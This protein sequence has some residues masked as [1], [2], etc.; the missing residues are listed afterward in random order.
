MKDFIEYERVIKTIIQTYLNL[1]SPTL[2]LLLEVIKYRYPPMINFERKPDM[3]LEVLGTRFNR[4]FDTDKNGFVYNI[5]LADSF[6]TGLSRL[7]VVLRLSKKFRDRGALLTLGTLSDLPYYYNQT[8]EY[9]TGISDT[10]F[11]SLT[12]PF[13]GFPPDQIRILKFPSQEFLEGSRELVDTLF[14]LTG[15][16]LTTIH[17]FDPYLVELYLPVLLTSIRLRKKEHINDIINRILS[18]IFRYRFPRQ[19]Y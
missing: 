4:Y 14:G 7:G 5:K 6:Y 12:D 19:T 17:G 8:M 9:V 3:Y 10:L 16:L 2:D 15:R 18:S 13:W 11:D 1:D